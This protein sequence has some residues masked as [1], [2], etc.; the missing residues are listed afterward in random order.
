MNRPY[1]NRKINGITGLQEVQKFQKHLKNCRK[2]P[3]RRIVVDEV[4][5]IVNATST[6]LLEALNIRAESGQ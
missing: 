6:S 4:D 1:C 2:N 3:K 5:G